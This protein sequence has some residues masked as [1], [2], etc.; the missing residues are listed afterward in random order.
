MT[1]HAQ[2]K[3]MKALALKLLS[4]PEYMEKNADQVKA[5]VAKA[6]SIIEAAKGGKEGG[7][8]GFYNKTQDKALDEAQKKADAAADELK[9]LTAQVD[10]QKAKIDDLTSQLTA[11]QQARDKAE[12]ALQL[13]RDRTASAMRQFQTLRQTLNDKA[14]LAGAFHQNY[15]ATQSSVS[16]VLSTLPESKIRRQIASVLA[17]FTQ[18]DGACQTAAQQIQARSAQAKADYDKLMDFGGL[19]PNPTTIQMGK[20]KILAPAEQDNAATAARRDQQVLM[21]EKNLDQGLKN[22]QALAN[23]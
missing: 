19:G 7:G 3:E 21:L 18:V 4:D 22:L 11:A 8:K 15:L 6:T 14:A 5:M 17:S 10:A 16:K 1:T 9:S 2:A 20:D 23:V 12:K 13:Y